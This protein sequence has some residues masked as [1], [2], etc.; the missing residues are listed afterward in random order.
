VRTLRAE[1]RLWK[2]GVTDDDFGV[3]RLGMGTL[4]QP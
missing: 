2:D 4:P 1:A 3:I